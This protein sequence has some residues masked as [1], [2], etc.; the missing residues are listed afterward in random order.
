MVGGLTNAV[1]DESSLGEGDIGVIASKQFA[2]NPHE[3]KFYTNPNK[4]KHKVVIVDDDEED[5]DFAIHTSI[6]N[7]MSFGSNIP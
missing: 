1:D 7:N 5:G 6:N 2:F 3:S 4:I